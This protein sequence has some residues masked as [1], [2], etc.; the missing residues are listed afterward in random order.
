ME[1]EYSVFNS[2]F[3][4]FL[5]ACGVDRE[6]RPSGNSGTIVQGDRRL[7]LDTMKLFIGFKPTWGDMD[8][9]LVLGGTGWN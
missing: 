3:G 8:I 9:A 1:Q 2:V 6:I 7:R 4:R 5:H